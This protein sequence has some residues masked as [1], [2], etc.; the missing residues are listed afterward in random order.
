MITERFTA[1][2]YIQEGTNG[3]LGGVVKMIQDSEGL[4]WIGVFDNG[5]YRFDPNNNTFQHYHLKEDLT[6]ND[7]RFRQNSV[8]DIVEDATNPAIL[9]LAGNNG[10]YR[11]D[12]TSEQLTYFDSTAPLT[13]GSSIQQIM[14]QD[15]NYLWL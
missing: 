10:L 7:A 15:S 3:A 12:K 8:L 5:F 9:W 11:F 6:D 4:I 1:F 13:Q 2:P 14:Q